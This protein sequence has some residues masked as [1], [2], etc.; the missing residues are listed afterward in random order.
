MH[1]HSEAFIQIV[2]PASGEAQAINDQRLAELARDGMQVRYQRLSVD[3]LWPFTAGTV[4]ARL[5]QLLKALRDSS[6]SILLASRGGYGASDLLD[7]IPW[8][9]LKN[10]KPRP[11]VGFS[12]ISALHSAFFTQLAWPGIHGPMPATEFW[13]Q[14]GRDDVEALI[15]L[16]QGHSPAIS[17]PLFFLGRG[18]APSI[19]GWGFGGCLSV[20]TNLIG[21][22]YFPPS[23]DGA[24]VYWEDIGEN[25][26][27]ILRFATQWLQSGALRGVKGLVLGRFVGCEVRDSYS[28]NQ[29]RH[30]LAS[31][32]GLPVWFSPSF[33]H[34][35]PNWPLPIGRTLRIEGERLSWDL[36]TLHG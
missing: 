8:N 22:P 27:R 9:E 33:G 6:V 36:D 13:G 29:L 26:A 21:T 15:A 17:L 32:I 20:L 35:S 14:H 7:H 19:R 28:E 30:Q 4:Q 25:P 1:A 3:P 24:L 31:R 16:M 2:S 11:I 18:L 10:L 5:D 23:L 12:D 34:C